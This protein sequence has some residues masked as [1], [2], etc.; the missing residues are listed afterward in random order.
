M[1]TSV[2][3]VTNCDDERPS[4]AALRGIVGALERR[5]DVAV[6]TLFLRRPH[7]SFFSIGAARRRRRRLPWPGERVVDDLRTWWPAAALDLVGAGVV[8]DALRGRRLRWWLR[9]DRPDVV[10]LDDGLGYRVIEHLHPRPICVSRLN[11]T[12]PSDDE[13]ESGPLP[14]PDVVL[15]A[16]D[17]RPDRDTAPPGVPLIRE[18]E[19][20]DL[21]LASSRASD[22]VRAGHRSTLGVGA[23][24]TLLTGWGF[25]GWLDGPDVFIRTLWSVR[26]RH[27]VDAVGVWFGDT[28]P[29]EHEELLTEARRAGVADV[30]HL[31]PYEGRGTA[32]EPAYSADVVV[33]PTRL[34][35]LREHLSPVIASGLAIATF[36]AAD[37]DDPT[38]SMVPDLDVE[39]LAAVAAE[40]LTETR[41]TRLDAALTEFDLDR[42]VGSILDATAGVPRRP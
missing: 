25:D 24:T 30:Y 21:A 27:G 1:A 5:A 34:A 31:L 39:A 16:I 3:V 17:V 38:V 28:S 37:L 35:L 6:S 26:E 10:L 40:L 14:D 20:L 23:D 42:W 2:L 7:R 32:P 13:L 4:T 15:V 41:A 33:L 18:R 29:E 36:A 12:R 19:Q 11:T 22:T 9:G 8:A